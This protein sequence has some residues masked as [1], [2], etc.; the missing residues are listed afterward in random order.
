MRAGDITSGQDRLW[1]QGYSTPRQVLDISHLEFYN[2]CRE[3]FCSWAHQR[4]NIVP[5]TRDRQLGRDICP[6][7]VFRFLFSLSLQV[8]SMI[9]H[10]SPVPSGPL[11][12]PSDIYIL[13]MT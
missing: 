7:Q 4:V 6:H 12:R 13:S 5:R 8:L 1:R 2:R 9:I 10:T 11:A 3:P